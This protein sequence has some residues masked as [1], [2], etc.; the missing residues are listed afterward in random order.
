MMSAD[1]QPGKNDEKA[2]KEGSVWTTQFYI[3]EEAAVEVSR[4][5]DTLRSKNKPK[6]DPGAAEAE[7]KELWGS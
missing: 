6:T 2:K 1:T 7:A 3:P 4:I 5:L